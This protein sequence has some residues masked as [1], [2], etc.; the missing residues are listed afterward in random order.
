MHTKLAELFLKDYIYVSE[1]KQKSEE[2]RYYAWRDNLKSAGSWCNFADDLLRQ[3][4]DNDATKLMKPACLWAHY[5][6][7]SQEIA[8]NYPAEVRQ[9]I[10]V[11][12]IATT[13]VNCAN[14]HQIYYP[15]PISGVTEDKWCFV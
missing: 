9:F 2:L 5:I 7:V 10:D 14:V 3:S 6:E 8:S 15:E 13:L 1:L 11:D 4:E 12:A